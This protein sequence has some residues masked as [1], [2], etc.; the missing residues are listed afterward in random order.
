MA[1]IESTVKVGQKPPKEALKRIRKEIK[2]AAK[3]PINLEDAP[4][5]SP[6]ALKEFAHLAAER[7][8]QKKRQVV[9]LRLVPDCLSKYKSLGK[10]YTSI[11]A[12]VLNY[13]ANNPEILSKFR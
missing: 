4:E 9:T 2:E 12:D 11:M 8:R 5:L 6:E 10:G 1:I 13:A 7:N 3:F